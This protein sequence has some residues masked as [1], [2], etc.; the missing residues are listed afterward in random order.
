MATGM[1]AK[2]RIALRR[3]A[4]GRDA[5]FGSDLS[6]LSPSVTPAHWN[7]CNEADASLMPEPV[8]NTSQRRRNMCQSSV[9]IPT[10]TL[11]RSN[12]GPREA[13]TGPL[14]CGAECASP[15]FA[16]SAIAN[17]SETSSVVKLQSGTEHETM[18]MVV[19]RM[20]LS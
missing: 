19:V 1:T 10:S 20:L 11:G 16:S 6:K 14:C 3:S 17:A 18:T 4:R 9:D 5:A 7:S 13:F 15:W 8:L 12:F 2:S